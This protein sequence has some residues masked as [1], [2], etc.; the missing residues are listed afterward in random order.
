[1]G[2]PIELH[3]RSGW[4]DFT[5]YRPHPTAMQLREWLTHTHRRTIELTH[6]FD[7]ANA[8][9]PLLNIVNPPV[10]EL[11]HVAWFQEFWM[12]RG[13][14]FQAPSLLRDADRWYDSM[15][16]AHDTRWT[17]DLPDIAFTRKYLGRVF[18]RCLQQ[19]DSSEPGDETAYFAQ[20]VLFHQDMHNEALTYTWQTLGLPAPL[21]ASQPRLGP[22]CDINVPEG[23]LSLGS[24]PGSGFV[25]DNE[26]WAHQVAVP[27]F[28][29]ASRVVSNGEYA[30]FVDAG[31]YQQ[32]DLWSKAGWSACAGQ[33]LEQPRYW[34]RKPGKPDGGNWMVRQFEQW[35]PLPRDQAAIHV[36]GHEAQAYCRWAGRRLPTETEWE[37][38]ARHSGPEF[39][40]GQVWEWTSSRFLP[41]AGFA[42]DPYKDYSEPWFLEDHRVLRGG[43]FATPRRLMRPGF[44]NFFKPERADM[45][46]GFRTCT[47]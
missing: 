14:D 29:I 1:M 7:D 31:G 20:L 36:S 30:D 45:F 12:Q 17:L 33:A 47:A 44:R 13:G 34:T 16:V 23:L 43:S 9:V 3:H 32:R 26:K 27:A 35:V 38:A 42:A 37:F 11:G 22:C 39:D 5:Q 28:T 10:W 41:Y 4:P 2:N 15:R 40:Y 6:Q 21:A 18:E 24:P 25:F 19:L 8:V 46:C